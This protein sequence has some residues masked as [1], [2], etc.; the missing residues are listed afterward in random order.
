MTEPTAPADDTTT[1]EENNG[2]VDATGAPIDASYG[3]N[4]TWQTGPVDTTGVSGGIKEVSHI[5]VFAQHKAD[6]LQ[7]AIDDLNGDA[8]SGSGNVS[9]DPDLTEEQTD[10]LIADLTDAQ[11]EAQ[12]LADGPELDEDGNPVEPEDGPV[13]KST[14]STGSRSTGSSRSAKAAEKKD[15]KAAETKEKTPSAKVTTDS[16]THS[17]THS[18]KPTGV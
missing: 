16:T 6:T 8:P 15:D 7:L 14:R 10:A 18:S 9:V 2:Q 1:E 12:A 5:P 11:A 13:A 3:L 17:T 4:A